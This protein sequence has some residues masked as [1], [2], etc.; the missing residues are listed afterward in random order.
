M[1]M[2][3]EIKVTHIGSRWHARLLV[4]GAVQDEMACA[5]QSDIGWISREMLRWVDKLG[6]TSK[7]AQAARQRQ[8]ACPAG[9]VWTYKQL[10]AER[11]ATRRVQ[12]F[13]K[14]R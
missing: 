5:E 1:G 6:G 2:E 14:Q 10:E 3:P 12:G 4:A 11:E 7:F 9:K 13:T 8:G